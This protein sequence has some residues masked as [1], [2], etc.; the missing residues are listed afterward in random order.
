M[1]ARRIFLASIVAT[2]LLAA[3]CL[4][5]VARTIGEMQT[6]HAALTKKFGEEVFVNISEA[7]ERITLSVTFI[8]SAL[9]DKSANDRAK[10]AQEAAN[11]VKT[12]YARAQ[13]LQAIWVFFVRQETK[14]IVFHYTQT[15]DYFG[16][17]KNAARLTTPSPASLPGIS[18]YGVE[19]R[20]SATYLD[21]ENESDISASGIQLAGIPGEKGL[22]ILPHFRV[23]GDVR[24]AKSRPP[25][26]V[27]LDFASYADKS[28]F[29][30]ITAIEFIADG[31]SVLRTGGTFTGT[32]TQFCYLTVPYS[33]FRKM[34]DAKQLT[35]KLGGKDYPLTPSQLS[36]I[37][38]M[39]NYVTE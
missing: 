2:S 14:M 8:N 11:V 38:Q 27:S 24:K 10:R 15:V 36:V 29:E 13:N 34:I 25:R 32:N 30:Q 5:Q 18:S 4:K 19:V 9:N 17:D 35:I 31:K 7:T 21:K 22:T 33:S 12:S 16:F 26:E 39:S 6:L 3:G 20:T 1:R 23:K 37:R 28:E